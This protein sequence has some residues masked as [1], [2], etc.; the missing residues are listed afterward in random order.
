APR[1]TS[2]KCLNATARCLFD[3]RLVNCAVPRIGDGLSVS[4]SVSQA[5][6]VETVQSINV[7]KAITFPRLVVPA[8]RGVHQL[9]TS[10][11]IG[12]AERISM[13]VVHV[14]EEEPSM[15][16][17]KSPRRWSAKVTETSDA[18]DLEDNIFESRSPRRIAAF[19]QAFRR[20]QSSPQSGS[21]PIGHVD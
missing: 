3:C 21:T 10:R 8:L 20:A 13:A 19:A 15:A 4:T 18:I 9:G 16:S 1:A 2:L 17:E 5:G 11:F 6:G 14:P 12:A 7:F